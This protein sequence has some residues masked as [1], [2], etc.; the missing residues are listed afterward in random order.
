MA[1]AS[2]LTTSE[3][4]T[5]GLFQNPCW[6]WGPWSHY[7]QCWDEKGGFVRE[8]L[9]IFRSRHLLLG[10][11]AGFWTPHRKCGGA[12]GS[13]GFYVWDGGSHLGWLG[14]VGPHVLPL[15]EGDLKVLW[16]TCN[17]AAQALHNVP[18]TLGLPSQIPLPTTQAVIGRKRSTQELLSLWHTWLGASCWFEN[19]CWFKTMRCHSVLPIMFTKIFFKCNI[20]PWKG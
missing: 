2:W 18:P 19:I 9:T 6:S 4:E 5:R 11:E 10:G 13:E 7:S 15:D 12:S 3:K 20:Q 16:N 1:E 14:R 17:L 8:R